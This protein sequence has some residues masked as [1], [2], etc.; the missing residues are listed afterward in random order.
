MAVADEHG[1][2]LWVCGPPGVLR[3]AE[4]I[5]F[6]EGAQLA[7]RPYRLTCEVSSDWAAVT[8]RL[9]AGDVQGAPGEPIFPEGHRKQEKDE[10]DGTF[11]G[12]RPIR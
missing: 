10:T 9:A 11:R 12:P 3:R 7:S 6:V 4:A 8:A 2:L 1:Q 5:S